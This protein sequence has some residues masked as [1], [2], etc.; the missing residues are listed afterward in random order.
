[1][2]A[3][4]VRLSVQAIGLNRAEALFRRGQYTQKPEFPSRIGYDAVGVVDAVG[5]EVDGVRVGARVA[6][7]PAFLMSRHGVYSESAVVP[8]HAIVPWPEGLE[9]EQAAGLWTAW[10]T[11]WGGLVKEGELR[12]GQWVL[13]TA[14]ASSVGLAAIQTARAEGAK[15]IATTRKAAKREALLRAGADHVIVTETEDVVARVL[16]I[17]WGHGADILFDAIAGPGLETLTQAMAMRGRVILYGYLGGLSTPLPLVPMLRKALTVR[18]HSIFHTT[19]DVKIMAEATGYVV[20]GVRRGAF[21]PPIDRVFSLE[22]IVEAHRYLEG[23]E[24]VGKIVVV[25][26]KK[27]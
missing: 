11:V 19:G 18:A 1:P 21:R 17:T 2:A 4:E 10:L 20:A 22:D 26:G 12:S 27:R 8:A 25:P 15:T 5:P 23:S 3:G 9:A 13:L 7:V 6:T 16:E 24:Q 14:A